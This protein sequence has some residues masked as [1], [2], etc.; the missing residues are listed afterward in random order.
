MNICLDGYLVL[1]R[2][3]PFV[4]FNKSWSHCFFFFFY[5]KSAVNAVE[6]RPFEVSAILNSHLEQ[7]V[8]IYEVHL[9]IYGFSLCS[10]RHPS[11]THVHAIPKKYACCALT[12]RPFSI[13]VWVWL[14]FVRS[15]GEYAGRKC[16]S[17][18]L[19]EWN[20]HREQ[21]NLR[22]S[23][24]S[25]VINSRS[26]VHNEC[27]LN[28]E[29]ILPLDLPI[30]FPFQNRFCGSRKKKWEENDDDGGGDDKTFQHCP[31][32]RTTY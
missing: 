3:C 31:P 22:L 8:T 13:F 30:H 17:H 7:T 12:D 4:P 26:F 23:A 10:L 6:S 5:R 32:D 14:D 25:T 2:P 21:C 15:R 18:C 27:S 24:I 16:V 9:W 19:H 11:I 1:A 28:A 29:Y 20:V